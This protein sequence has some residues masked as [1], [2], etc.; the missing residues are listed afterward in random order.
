MSHDDFFRGV[1]DSG[2]DEGEESAVLGVVI[3]GGWSGDDFG[4][5]ICMRYGNSRFPFVGPVLGFECPLDWVT[6]LDVTTHN[7]NHTH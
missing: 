3:A 1:V 6:T 5:V 2:S 7:E 4:C